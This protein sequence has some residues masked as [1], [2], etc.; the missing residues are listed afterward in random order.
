MPQIGSLLIQDDRIA[1]VGPGIYT[2]PDAGVFECNG[3]AIAP[4]F[5]D[6]HSHSDLHL[7]V[8]GPEKL[9]Q[10]VTSEVVGNCGFS[11]FPS[12]RH[13]A[14][15][16]D[17]ANPILNGG[18]DWGWES[19]REYLE[20][21]VKQST[22][23]NVY[24]LTGHGTLRVAHSGFRQGPLEADESDAMAGTLGDCIAGGSVGFSTGLMYAPGS[25][26]PFE[27]LTALCQVTARNGGIYCTHMRS[28]SWELLESLE[29]QIQLAR[30]T[31]CKLQISHLQAVGRVN[32]EKQHLAFER[33]EVARREGVDIEFDIYPYQAGST[34][35]SQLLPQRALVKTRALTR[36]LPIPS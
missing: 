19:S 16:H 12:C 9:Q 26:A 32:W 2:P 34:V 35:C 29:E 33:M 24:S 20:Q 3:L 13:A 21:A 36:A 8:N 10:G 11:A 17:Y 18:S 4:G 30:L 28:Y 25:S 7:L 22:I 27:E 1:E 14:Q 5:V 31:G 15:V 6:I 23:A